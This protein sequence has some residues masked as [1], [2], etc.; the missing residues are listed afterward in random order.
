MDK[1][2]TAVL[3][4]IFFLLASCN[5]E[6]A[7]G[8]GRLASDTRQVGEFKG[9]SLSGSG[10]LSIKQGYKTSLIIQTDDN[11]L[12]KIESEVSDG[13]LHIGPKAGFATGPLSPTKGISYFVTIRDL[14]QLY[15]SGVAEVSTIEEIMGDNLEIHMEGTGHMRLAIEMENV[16]LSIKGAGKVHLRGDAKS[17]IIEIEGAGVYDGSK[18]KTKEAKAIIEGAGEVTLTVADSLDVQ[19]S[20]AGTVKYKG[21]PKI[22]SKVSGMGTVQKI[23]E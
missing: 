23:G 7:R 11:L 3:Y 21:S 8:S 20:G 9:V 15:V 4:P 5:T 14:E 6:Q 22:S 1:Y 10:N 19:I 17:Q 18:L 12:D 13:V 16:D 2:L